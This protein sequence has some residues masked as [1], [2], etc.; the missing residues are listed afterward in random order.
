MSGKPKSGD[1]DLELILDSVNPVV[2]FSANICPILWML[3]NNMLP[4]LSINPFFWVL[5]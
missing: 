2:T 4:C 1:Q 3:Q 5:Q